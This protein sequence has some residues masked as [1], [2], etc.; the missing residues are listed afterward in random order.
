MK[1]IYKN[2]FIHNVIAHPL[3]QI[4]YMVGCPNLADKVHNG[5]VPTLGKEV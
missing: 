3:M 5:T 2:W 1:R 4:L